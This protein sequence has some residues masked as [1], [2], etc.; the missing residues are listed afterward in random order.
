[1]KQLIERYIKAY[2][3]FDIEGMIELLDDSIVFENYSGGKLN[4]STKGLEEFRLTAQRAAQLFAS[5][6]QK[7]R[8]ICVMDDKTIVEI[9]YEAVLASDLSDSLKAGDYLRLAGKS[10][11][12][13]ASGKINYIADY[14]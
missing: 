8:N 14:S 7:I 4:L 2:N 6:E 9:D 10:I 1:M 3:R 11:F 13:S 12:Q 5:R